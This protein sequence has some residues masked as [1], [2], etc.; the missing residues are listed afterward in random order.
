M[1][2]WVVLHAEIYRFE[3]GG[4][5]GGIQYLSTFAILR[6]IMHNV[7]CGSLPFLTIFAPILQAL[8]EAN[9]QTSFWC[10]NTSPKSTTDRE[11]IR[12]TWQESSI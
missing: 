9:L 8:D 7:R 10:A 6:L 11:S 5:T 3:V 2:V 4:G 1:S 12:L